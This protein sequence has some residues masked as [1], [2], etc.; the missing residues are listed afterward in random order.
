MGSPDRSAAS[1]DTIRRA[2]TKATHE[3]YRVD[4]QTLSPIPGSQERVPSHGLDR[5]AL[6]ALDALVAER[7]RYRE[8]LN[9]LNALTFEN[10]DDEKCVRAVI[11]EALS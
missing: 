2:L 6:V 10:E 5:E 11:A 8:A 4:P 1:V 9:D 3:T 7:D